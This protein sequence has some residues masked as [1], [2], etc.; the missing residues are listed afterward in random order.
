MNAMPQASREAAFL[1]EVPIY[2]DQATLLEI[3]FGNTTTGTFP[4][5]YCHN[6]GEYY[7]IETDIFYNKLLIV[8]FYFSLQQCQMIMDH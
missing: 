8:Y 3:I 7:S 5:L 1:L 2:E 6:I 4:G